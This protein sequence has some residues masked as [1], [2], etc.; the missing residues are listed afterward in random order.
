MQR[1]PS[2]SES[3]TASDVKALLAIS[4]LYQSD[5]KLLELQPDAYN[6]KDNVDGFLQLPTWYVAIPIQRVWK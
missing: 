2:P 5:E 6:W 1:A 3:F 4:A